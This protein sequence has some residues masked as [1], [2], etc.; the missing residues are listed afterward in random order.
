MHSAFRRGLTALALLA[1]AAVPPAVAQS[2]PSRP[3]TLVV[4][5]GPGSGSDVTARLLAAHLGPDLGQTVVVENRAGGSGV[6]A[7]QSVARAPADG[8][9][10]LFSSTAQLVVVP[11]INATA[12]WQLAD[13]T[14]VAP[15]L[16]APFALLVANTDAAPRTAQELAERLRKEPQGYASAGIGTMTHLGTE[17][18]LRSIGAK[19]THVPYK[20]SG[21]SLTDLM[22][23]QT[24]FTV[25]SLTASMAHLRSGRLRA[26]AVMD[27][28]RK[29]SLP[30]V[31]TIDETG[32]TGTHASVVAGVFGP[33]GMPADR[34]ERLAAAMAKVLSLAEVQQKLAASESERLTVPVPEFVRLLEQESTRW[35]PLVR[36]L[37]LKVE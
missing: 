18:W 8:Y 3:I 32:A 17:L 24:L 6:L 37:A 7:H 31:P 10:L 21:Q 9:T 22:G 34:V 4:P 11:M 1:A 20:G 28:Q 23:G 16:K 15:V 30:D 29:A 35:G 19:A 33:R 12:R 26:L 2:F 36:E 13:F 14:P 27:G 5:Q 25:D